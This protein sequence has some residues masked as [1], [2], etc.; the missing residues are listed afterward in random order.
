[1]RNLIYTVK[2]LLKRPLFLIKEIKNL[3][4]III[5]Q[6]QSRFL[7]SSYQTSLSPLEPIK[8]YTF[9]G[10]V[11]FAIKEFLALISNELIF[12]KSILLDGF[13]D[14]DLK[15]MYRVGSDNI[16][17]PKPP[18]VELEKNR[19]IDSSI[20]K[21][22][23]KSY[24]LANSK[25][26]D[27]FDRASWWEEMSR[28]FKRELFNE[29]GEINQEYL[30]KFRGIQELPANI[31]KDQFLVVNRKFGYYISYLKAIDLILE[32]HRHAKVVKKEI[33][34]SLSES[35]AG[36]NL[37]VHYRGL[38]V[39][40][41][42]LFHSIIIDNILSNT[43]LPQRATIWE[44]GAGYGGLA[45]IMKSYIP[46]SC[47]I[48]LDLPET[49][50]YCSYFIAY[51]FPNKKIGY[52]SDI[53]DRLD[54]FDNITKEYDF[55]LIP[56]WVSPYIKDC[57]IDLVIDTYSMSEMSAI[58]AQYYLS[59][60]DRTL[61]KGGYFYSIN[62]R[63]K[64][65]DDKLPFYEWKFKSQFNTILYEYSK[66]IHPQWLGVKLDTT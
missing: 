3:Y 46:N 5:Y 12:K 40:I 45:R 14:I 59:H 48:L 42:L 6:P 36:E 65:E 11:G 24:H 35:Y 51:N 16:P 17:Y 54:K 21:T 60:I 53:I 1:M 66:Y 55:L 27:R 50:T 39:S 47:Y 58:Y 61:K 23:E 44:I 62:K 33:L 25:D 18:L 49:L 2:W 56:P 9:I 4:Q 28:A 29:N 38:R 7:L 13:D 30:K 10:R 57:S 20:F 37:S 34:L 43:K 8:F 22:I 19:E 15:E 31:V 52:L 32:Y 26:P 64:R 41:R 63:F